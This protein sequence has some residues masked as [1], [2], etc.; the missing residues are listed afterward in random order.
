MANPTGAIPGA[1]AEEPVTPINNGE[2]TSLITDLTGRL[3]V[4]IAATGANGIPI[5]IFSGE[6]GGMQVEDAVAGDAL[7][8][9]N[10]SV[11]EALSVQQHGTYFR[12]LD[13][14]G[15]F[16]PQDNTFKISPGRIYRAQAMRMQGAGVAYLQFYARFDGLTLVAADSPIAVIEINDSDKKVGSIDFGVFGIHFNPALIA[17]V[18]SDPHKFT[19]GSPIQIRTIAGMR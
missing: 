6:N 17:I 8:G 13:I 11:I 18:S 15:A 3:R 5:D 7:N 16:T 2:T 10:A 19:L 1:R 4:R 14:S 9:V 12:S